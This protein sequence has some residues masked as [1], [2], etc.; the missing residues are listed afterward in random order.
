M[1]EHDTHTDVVEKK[2]SRLWLHPTRRHPLERAVSE[3]IGSAWTIAH[4]TDLSDM[5]CH[6]CAI[7]SDNAFAVFMKYG[8]EPEAIQ[9]FEVEVAGLQYLSQHAGVLTPPAIGIVPLEDGTVFIMEALH[10]VERTPL[11]WRDIGATLARIHGVVAEQCGFSTH[12]FAGPLLLD[13][14]LTHDW[15]SFYGERRLWPRLQLALSSG[16]LPVSVA[17]QVETVIRRLPELCAS[18]IT[19]SLLH[20]DAQQNNFVTT[21]HGTFVIDPA[22][23]YGHHESDVALLDSFQ[24]VP[25]E[26]FAGYTEHIPL[27]TGFSERRNL[28]RIPLYLAAVALEGPCHLQRLT[29]AL[30]GYL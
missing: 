3:Y 29:N 5:A 18:A 7:A 4:I 20:G 26:V 14:T 15:V 6:P 19:P 13:N 1:N 17:S 2:D 12:G 24:P 21:P 10:I 8:A 22:I 30:Q 9:Q 25:D 27:D 28:W 23:Y 16:H 11:H